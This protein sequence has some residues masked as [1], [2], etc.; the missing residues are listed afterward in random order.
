MFECTY[1]HICVMDHQSV[2]YCMQPKSIANNLFFFFQLNK[3]KKIHVIVK[4]KKKGEGNIIS[5]FSNKRMRIYQNIECKEHFFK[6]KRTK[7]I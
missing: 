7:R 6:K 1:V 2:L 5:N 4:K 3:K